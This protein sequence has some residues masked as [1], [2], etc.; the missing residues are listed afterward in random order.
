[1]V[2]PDLYPVEEK[3]PIT[4]LASNLR[5]RVYVGEWHHIKKDGSM[6]TIIVT[7]HD[8]VYMGRDARIGVITDITDR[9]KA[10]EEIQKLNQTLEE[11]V[12]ERTT[13][14]VSINKELESFSYSISHDLRAP[15]RAI[16]G[17]SQ[18]LSSRHRSSLN[19]EG[20][21]YM[22]Y[23]VEASIR[24]EQLINDLL[25]YS[26]LGR[27]SLDIRSI[28]L[29]KII[30]NIY[31][32]FKQKLEEIGGN[33]IVDKELPEIWGDE[34]LFMQI[35][36][37]LVENAIIYRRTDEPL[38]ISINGERTKSNFVLKISDNGIGISPEYW[39]KIFNIFQR[40]HGEDKYPGTGIGLATVR[41]AVSMLDGKV[42]VESVVGKGSIF[43]ISLPEH[44]NNIQHG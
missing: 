31:T 25:N 9:K 36:T 38:E 33:F 4:Q 20:R 34:S 26:R 42:W 43:F 18:I 29:S 3:G 14:L 13:Q 37:N 5:G 17:F 2:L 19:D 8:V 28:P 12:A 10:E 7:S 24:M 39:E 23:I 6:I 15:L 22:D 27:K 11:R 16:Y 1:M 35:F 41:K 30:S 32:D 21:Q 44:K 40:L